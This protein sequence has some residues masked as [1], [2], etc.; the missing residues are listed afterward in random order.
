[1]YPA[2]LLGEIR[3]QSAENPS[4]ELHG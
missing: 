4:V 2:V 3:E 1:E